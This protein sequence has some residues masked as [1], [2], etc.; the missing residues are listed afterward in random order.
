MDPATVM[1]TLADVEA[2]LAIRQVELESIADEKVRVQ[3][4]MDKTMAR[5]TV[6][7]QGASKEIRQSNALLAVVTSG[8]DLYERLTNLDARYESLKAA[9]RALETRA[10]IGQSILR[11]L[12]N[13]ANRSSRDPA[14]SQS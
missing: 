6:V 1:K 10:S 3:R 12:T 4:D 11:A 7:A 5:A 14:W 9:M 2:D 13:E 8:S